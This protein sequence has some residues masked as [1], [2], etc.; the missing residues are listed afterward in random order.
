MISN[1][2]IRKKAEE[3]VSAK[4]TNIPVPLSL[5]ES[6]RLLHEL[7]VHQVELEIQ[8]EELRRAQAEV[9]T[10]RI[11]YVD[12][13]DQAPVGYCTVSETGLVLDANLTA[14]RL[15]GMERSALVNQL[16]SRFIVR[17]DEN[18]FYGYLRQLIETDVPQ[19]SELRMQRQN[20]TMFW[21]RLEATAG[22]DV[23][24]AALCRLVI[25]DINEPKRAEALRMSEERMS[26]AMKATGLGLYDLDLRTGEAVVNDEYALMLGYAP[27]QFHETNDA[28]IARLHPDDRKPVAAIYQDYIQGRI[29]E[30]RLEFRQRTKDG[31]WKWIL[32][33]GMIVERNAAGEPVRMLGTHADITR[34][35]E[36]EKALYEM[37]VTVREQKLYSLLVD[38]AAD[39]FWLLDK[40]FMTVYTNPALEK[41]LGYA[42]EEMLGRSWSDFG[43][44]EWVA[45]AQELEKRRESGVQEPHH[46]LFIH[47]DGRNVLTRIATTPL[48]DQ[49][50]NFNGALG[51]VSDITRQQEAQEA[52][53]VKDMLNAV[54]KASGIGMSLINPDYTIEW[55]ND[56]Y[57]Q[58]FG[59]LEKAKGRNCFE[60]FEK[61][62]AICTGCPARVSFEAGATST[63]E[64]RGIST[65]VGAD[66]IM[67]M[68]TSPILNADGK[69]LQVVEITQDIT[70]R[71]QAEE[72]VQ[73]S[74]DEK[75][76]MLKE[77]HHRVKNNMQVISSLLNLQAREIA[78]VSVRALFEESRNRI[79]SMALIHE[80]LYRS[81]DFAHVDFREYLKRLTEDIAQTFKRSGV[82]IL[83]EMESVELDVNAGIPCGLIVNELISNSLKHAFPGNRKG[84]I[85]VGIIRNGEGDN[86]LFVA[87]DGI[88]IAPDIDY[89][90]ST[91]LG[92]KL[93]YVLSGQIHGTIA[94][95]ADGGTKFSI[96]FP[97]GAQP[98]K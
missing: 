90:N 93:V 31:T 63:V 26:L 98:D 17:E 8:N 81:R 55:Y 74:L 96:T 19:R 2:N 51:I 78:D 65:S 73:R 12:L 53:Q 36:A 75:T 28:W 79:S 41:M 56:L 69:V 3:K 11:R 13:Y 23:D 45:R 25:S 54:A 32:S 85:R 67:T 33:H 15:L 38:N 66:R 80:R 88:G 7:R 68:T 86:L 82:N 21:A 9:A 42:K 87:D 89:H 10:A 83:V 72:Q 29:P 46:F 48:Y 64:R 94:L 20:G 18:S 57:V 16:F 6:N 37:K 43:D 49:D 24:G 52:L 60:V 84:T 35:K 47:K 44:P 92:L 97:G 14:A 58:W 76:V 59:P 30:Y 27:K 62:D 4:E 77:I 22:Q 71:K 91:T 50:G 5:E 95:S 70:E 34:D 40:A 39:G 61:R 1:D